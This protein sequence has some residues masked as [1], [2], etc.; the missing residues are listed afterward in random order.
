MCKRKIA[1]VALS[2]WQHEKFA[3]DEMVKYVAGY[4]LPIISRAS[5]AAIEG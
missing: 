2:A 3:S 1:S 5:L 4:R